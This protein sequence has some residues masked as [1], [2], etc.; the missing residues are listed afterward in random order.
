MRTPQPT[1][2][3]F[4]FGPAEPS[5]LLE[6]AM[7]AIA[8]WRDPPRWSALMSRGMAIDHSWDGPAAQYEALYE[9]G[10]AMR[11]PPGLS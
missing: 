2:N 10:L 1:G 6:A 5:A 9:R 8:A 7:R 11:S 4:V 3:G